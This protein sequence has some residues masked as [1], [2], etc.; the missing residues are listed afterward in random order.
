MRR[1]ERIDQGL[2]RWSAWRT[3]GRGSSTSAYINSAYDPNRVSQTSDVRAGMGPRLGVDDRAMVHLERA[4][5]LLPDEIRAAV[6]AV[7]SRQARPMESI[8]EQLGITR[9]TLHTR[10][11]HADARIAEYLA[12]RQRQNQ[13]RNLHTSGH[14]SVNS[15]GDHVD[16]PREEQP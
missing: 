4:V 1:V 6:F 13:F 11:C 3:V 2:H 14:N 10:L 7:Y 16:T 15:G 5:S 12:A 8:A 9:R